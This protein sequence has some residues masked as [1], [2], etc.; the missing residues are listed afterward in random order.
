MGK[1]LRGSGWHQ[2]HLADCPSPLDPKPVG[3]NNKAQCHTVS[4]KWMCGFPK[5]SARKG[6]VYEMSLSKSMIL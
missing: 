6:H 1:I 2:H 5:M 4:W 3:P